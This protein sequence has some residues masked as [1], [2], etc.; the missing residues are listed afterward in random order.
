MDGDGDAEFGLGFLIV[1]DI[2]KSGEIGSAGVYG[3][4]G[5]FNTSYWIDPE[6]DMVA[7]FMSQMRPTKSDITT[8]FRTLVYQALK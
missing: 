3:W 4:G 6:E 8:R 7:V 2:G 1:N 5:A